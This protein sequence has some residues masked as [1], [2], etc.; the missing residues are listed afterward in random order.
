MR[1]IPAI[2]TRGI[3]KSV[4]LSLSRYFITVRC[5]FNDTL[6]PSALIFRELRQNFVISLFI[7]STNVSL[8]GFGMQLFFYSCEEKQ[9]TFRA[10]I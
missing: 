5:A 3:G 4:N 1:S 10:S 2:P 9:V 7:I 8:V 6:A